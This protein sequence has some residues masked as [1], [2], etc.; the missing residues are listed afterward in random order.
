MVWQDFLLVWTA[1]NEA[2]H[3]HDT[4][5]QQQA[6]KR[7]VRLEMEALHEQRHRVLACDMDVFIGDTPAALSHYLDTTNATQVQNWLHI[8]KPFI[9]SSVKSAQ[10]LSLRGVQTMS[11][12]FPG[13]G[14]NRRPITSRSHR[15]ARPK[16]RDERTLPQLAYRFQSLRSCCGTKPS[17]LPL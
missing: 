6:Q 9:Q 12:Y 14:A 10:D 2:I 1:R 11:T 8:W 13:T 17:T 15:K 5:S 16:L 3:S 4:A 7:K